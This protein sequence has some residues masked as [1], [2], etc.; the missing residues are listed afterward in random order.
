M[1]YLETFH[2]KNLKY[3]LI[4]KFFYLKTKKIPKL[5]KIVLNFSCKTTNLK[6]LASSALALELISQKSAKFT[7]T[8]KSNIIL[9]I[10]KGNPVGCKVIL[11]K[12]NMFKFLDQLLIEI[13]SNLK[14]FNLKNKNIKN[15]FSFELK[16]TLNFVELKDHY[17]LFNNLFKCNIV[18]VVDSKTKKELNFVLTYFQLPFN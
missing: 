2:N 12:L 9:K 11:S 3:D 4:N 13:I 18:F 14:N 8:K 1:H 5:K 15:S 17:S 10:R 6:V 7:K 16:E